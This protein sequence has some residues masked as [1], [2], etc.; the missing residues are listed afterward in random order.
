MLYY[1]CKKIRVT[2]MKGIDTMKKMTKIEMFTL[3]AT[4]LTNQDEIDFINH[5]IELLENKKSSVRKPTVNQVENNGFMNEIVE[6]L[7]KA[8]APM[9]IADIQAS[10][11]GELATISN[12]RISAILKK[13]VD[14]GTVVKTYD[15]RKAYFSLA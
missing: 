13:L 15:K 3:I 7:G 2:P 6:I 12:Q 8:D 1:V 4:R 14:N 9:M 10:A 5:E 11:S